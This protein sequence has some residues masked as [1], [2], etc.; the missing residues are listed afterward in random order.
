MTFTGRND[1]LQTGIVAGAY[2]GV[3]SRLMIGTGGVEQMG[4]QLRK[5]GK[6]SSQRPLQQAQLLLR[7]L[8]QEEMRRQTRSRERPMQAPHKAAVLQVRR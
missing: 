2:F 3:V 8:E 7:S 1:R 6:A 5:G 4:V